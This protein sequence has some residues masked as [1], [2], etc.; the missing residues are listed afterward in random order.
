MAGK[1]EAAMTESG[2]FCGLACKYAGL[3]KEKRTFSIFGHG[4][5]GHY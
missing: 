3:L 2:N 5:F 4:L 1:R